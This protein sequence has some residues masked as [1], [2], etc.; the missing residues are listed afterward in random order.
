VKT[1][2]VKATQQMVEVVTPEGSFV[3]ASLAR[4]LERAAPAAPP[5]LIHHT[6]Q[7]LEGMLGPLQHIEV[8]EGLVDG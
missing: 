1:I 3:A 6:A 5:E 8:H 4:A 2:V 7:V